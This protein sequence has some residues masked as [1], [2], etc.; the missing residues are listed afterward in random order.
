[1]QGREIE[2][3]YFQIKLKGHHIRWLLHYL[4]KELGG[5][6]E[7]Y[8]KAINDWQNKKDEL[9]HQSPMITVPYI[10]SGG[11]VVSRP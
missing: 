6:R 10:Q 11:T 7:W 2:F 5:F 4:K 8:P 3:G 1:M 9:C